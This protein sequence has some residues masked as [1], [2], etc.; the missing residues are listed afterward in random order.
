MEEEVCILFFYRL[1][2]RDGSFATADVWAKV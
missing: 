1:I 2:V